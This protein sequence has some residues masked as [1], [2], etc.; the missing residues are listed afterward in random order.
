[1]I[2]SQSFSSIQLERILKA[3]KRKFILKMLFRNLK[4]FL[5]LISSFGIV[6]MEL[7]PNFKCGTIKNLTNYCF[8]DSSPDIIDFIESVKIDVS[9]EDILNRC[10]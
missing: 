1:M 10:M 5:I 9:E 8:N 2:D 7:P 3:V 6:F 4:C